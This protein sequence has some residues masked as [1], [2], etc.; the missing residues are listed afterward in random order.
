M[1]LPYDVAW[2]LVIP[3]CCVVVIASAGWP[4]NSGSRL[5]FGIGDERLLPRLL[6]VADVSCTAL[7]M[8]ARDRF[9]SVTTSVVSGA[10][11]VAQLRRRRVRRAVAHDAAAC[12][13]TGVG[14]VDQPLAV[15]GEHHRAAGRR[16]VHDRRGIVDRVHDHRMQQRLVRAASRDRSRPPPVRRP[17]AA[18]PA[19]A[20]RAGRRSQAFRG[21]GWREHAVD[22]VRP[23]EVVPLV[24]DVVAEHDRRRSPCGAARRPPR[25]DRRR[26]P[27]TGGRTR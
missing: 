3:R 17:A 7:Q 8:R 24:L 12:E 4:G 18:C 13:Q 6:R 14:R 10:I 27:G 26:L 16:G 5:S 25:S 2:M 23:D 22:L 21:P 20:A 11:C 19:T 15:T 9:W 1:V